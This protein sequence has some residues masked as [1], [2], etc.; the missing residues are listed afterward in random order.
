[1]P[2]TSYL[3]PYTSYLIPYTSCLKQLLFIF[4]FFFTLVIFSCKKETIITSSDARISVSADTIRFDTVFTSV[5]SITQSFK[6][7]NE[8]NQKLQFSS[9][10]LQGGAASSFKINVNG[11]VGPE[12][13]DIEVE[14]KDSIYVFVTVSL[15]PNISPLP[16]IIQDSI[17]INYNGNKNLVQLESWGQNANFLRSRIITGKVT[18]TNNLPY[19]IIGGLSVDTNATLTIEKGCRIYLHADAPVIIDGTLLLNGEKYDS[20]RIY[21][22]GDRLDDP[23]RNFPA[24]WPGI[25]F[26]GSSK[27]NVLNWAVIQNAYQG[28]VTEQPSVNS[29]PRVI[30]NQCIID[31]IYDAGILAIKSSI[32]ANNCLISN[33]GKNIQLINGG[34]YQFNH[35]TVPSFTSTYQSHKEPVLF[36]SNNIKQNN[37][38]TSSDMTA[39]FRNCIFW[40]ESGIVDDEV[41]TSKQGN[42]IFS[43]NFEN[44]LWRVKTPPANVVATNIII[45]QLPVFDS[46]NSQKHFFNFRLKNSSPA[47]NKGVNTGLSLDLDGNPRAVGLPD[48]G[49]FELQ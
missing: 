23:Y 22:K 1:M 4:I 37:I 25:Y 33:C 43:V 42:T 3:I 31:N 6:I 17:E 40:A 32:N 36:V 39:N 5:G 46:I 34:K 19:V 18:W 11:I 10:S 12:V 20:T 28:I 30:L 9:I 7:K 38:I 2:H 35:C 47:I 14:A 26:R 27:D 48:L 45:N 24:G 29:N 41:V 8:N 16:F 44:C 21:F 13:K 49:A 15:N